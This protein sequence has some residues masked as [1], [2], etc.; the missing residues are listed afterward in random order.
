MGKGKRSNNFGKWLIFCVSL[1]FV[2]YAFFLGLLLFF[3]EET[4]ATLTSYRQEYGERNEVI[5]NRY[6][7]QFGYTFTVNGKTYNG[8][9]QKV[10]S[11]VF[12][13]PTPTSTIS[14]NYLSCCPYL[15]A[16][17]EGKKNWKSILIFLGIGLLLFY[18]FRKM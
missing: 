10:S 7:Y 4:E 17:M 16:H 2:G 12:L 13:K 8:T 1:L 14:I 3:G 9:G 5:P 18:F 15:N 6:T 11:P